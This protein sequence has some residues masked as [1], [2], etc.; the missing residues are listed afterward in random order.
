VGSHRKG[1]GILNY[2]SFS[3]YGTSEKYHVGAIRNAELCRKFYPDFVPLFYIGPGVPK[4]VVS[5]L[6]ARG[7]KLSHCNNSQISNL[8][9]WRFL[10]VEK[11]NADVVLVRD[12]DSRFSDR[13]CQAVEQWLKSDK[14]FHVM[15]DYPAHDVP[16]MGGL[17]GCK[18]QLGLRV[19]DDIV[20]WLRTGENR[21]QVD[22]NF[23]AEVVWPKVKHS[24]MQHD[25]FFR[26]KYPGSIPFPAGDRTGGDFVGEVFN[27]FD[28]PQ[29]VCRYGRTIG[30][31]AEDI[32]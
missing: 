3:L 32:V 30:K 12:A 29:S 13:E 9:M 24:V 25:T 6:E 2:I 1:E 20:N 18:K 31:K 15:R 5:D 28:E 27:E 19:Y 23:L 22:Q 17:W 10:A 14:L 7:S 4:S 16:I 8:M 11:P 21:S 26:D